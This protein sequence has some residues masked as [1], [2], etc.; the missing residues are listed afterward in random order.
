MEVFKSSDGV[1]SHFIV[2]NGKQAIL[3]C[4]DV[5]RCIIFITVYI[6]TRLCEHYNIQYFWGE[7]HGSAKVIPSKEW[8]WAEELDS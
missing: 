5:F 6:C 8:Q 3:K 1:M 7:E 2:S 4:G